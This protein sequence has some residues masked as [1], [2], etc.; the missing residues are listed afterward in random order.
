MLCHPCR[1][2]HTR[3]KRHVAETTLAQDTASTPPPQVRPAL[4]PSSLTSH[5]PTGPSPSPT[6]RS[7]R[8][9]L[10]RGRKWTGLL[11]VYFWSTC[12][13]GDLHYIYTCSYLHF[14]GYVLLLQSEKVCLMTSLKEFLMA[15]VL[16]FYRLALRPYCHHL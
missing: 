15:R 12:C 11:W 1:R 2:N 6:L 5:R 7:P 16:E 14:Y 10:R 4:F 13:P 3:G 8:A 9:E